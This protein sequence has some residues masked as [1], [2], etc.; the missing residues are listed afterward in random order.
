M[1]ETNILQLDGLDWDGYIYYPYTCIENNGAAK[2]KIHFALHGCG[3]QLNSIYGW[4]WINRSGYNE[5][6]AT[7]N[8][9][10]VYPN[11]FLNVLLIKYPC[12]DIMAEVDK[13]NYLFKNGVQ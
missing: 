12:F 5:Y 3:E 7:N 4:E 13:E 11:V 2:C 10:I 8:I 6:A 9:I 1:L